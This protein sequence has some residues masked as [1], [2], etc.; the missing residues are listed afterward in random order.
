MGSKLSNSK[1]FNIIISI[2][3]AVALWIYVV[4]VEN[5]PGSK[6]IYDIP[7]TVIGADELENRG[8]V[9]SAMS[10]D[11]FDLHISGSR[12]AIIKVTDENT[13]VS[14][15]V[16][17]ITGEGKWP[18]KCKVTLPTS[19]TTGTVTTTDRNNYVI[20]VTVS[21]LLTKTVEVRGEFKGSVPDGY[22]ADSFVFSP[23]NITVSGQE[24]HVNQVAYALVTIAQDQLTKTFKDEEM[25]YTLMNAAG[26]KLTNLNVKCSVD[27]LSVTLPI[28]KVAEIPLTVQ[29][30]DG[31]G[32]TADDVAYTINPSSIVVSGE[33]DVLEPLKE[34]TLGVVDLSTVFDSETLTF[35]IPLTSELTNESGITSATITIKINN[36]ST[37]MMEA[38]NIEVINIPAGYDVSIITQS[39]QVWVRGTDDQIANI[40]NYQ[41]RAVADLSDVS[42]YTGQFKVPVKI[43]LDDASGAGVVGSD[44][45]IT[46]SAKK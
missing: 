5:L 27:T 3:L 24:D 35:P 38:T 19:I 12:N 2:L 21:K 9:I 23:S 6:T 25:G 10:T 33:P 43:Y 37:K 44:Y 8:L 39:L 34:I 15:D 4:S 16:S 13:T 7:I 14:L 32:A 18:V 17:G 29:I 11:T 46:I 40:S 22:Q 30:V 31:G 42:M 28:V 41:L 45:S 20:T 26:E 1:P 36:L